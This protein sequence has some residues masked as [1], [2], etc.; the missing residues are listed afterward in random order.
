[1]LHLTFDSYELP[2]MGKRPTYNDYRDRLTLE[3]SDTSGLP[4]SMPPSSEQVNEKDLKRRRR[5]SAGFV[6]SF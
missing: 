3:S 6:F 4:P 2:V 5:T 1:M